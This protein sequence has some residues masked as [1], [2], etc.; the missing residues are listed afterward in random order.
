VFFKRLN[1]GHPEDEALVVQLNGAT[2]SYRLQTFGRFADAS[3]AVAILKGFPEEC[4]LEDRMVFACFNKKTPVG[5]LQVA[6]H[7][8]SAELCS[9]GLLLIS[10]AQQRHH[11][12]CQAIEHLSRQARSWAGIQRFHIAVL[13]SNVVGL[14]FWRHCGFTTTQEDCVNP[15]FVS[16]GC[17]MERPIKTKPQ[18]QC[19]GREVRQENLAARHLLAVLR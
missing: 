10:D 1:P 2:P 19:H 18:C 17:V 16:R 7:W 6:R 11:F 4:A 12:G 15:A 13:D 14:K 5:L 8:P 9:I 3:D